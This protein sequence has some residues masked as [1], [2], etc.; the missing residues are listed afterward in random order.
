VGWQTQSPSAEGDGPL[1]QEEA[2]TANA[3]TH[4][5]GIPAQE[6]IDGLPTLFREHLA[7][8]L[9][10]E[11][12]FGIPTVEHVL[13]PVR[14]GYGEIQDPICQEWIRF[15]GERLTALFRRLYLR[16]GAGVV[17]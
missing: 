14:A 12:R 2:R 16:D 17:G 4:A 9:D 6:A 11:G 13:P 5:K 1:W 15:R 7:R 3:A 8:V 10:P